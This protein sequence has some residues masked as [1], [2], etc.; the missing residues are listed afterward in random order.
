MVSIAIVIGGL[1]VTMLAH[2][3]M[4]GIILDAVDVAVSRVADSVM[5]KA[6]DANRDILYQAPALDLT[7]DALAFERDVHIPLSLDRHQQITWVASQTGA[8]IL[9]QEQ[10]SEKAYYSPLTSLSNVLK[11][12]PSQVAL[13]SC[14]NGGMLLAL[15][16]E[17]QTFFQW[18]ALAFD[19][20]TQMDAQQKSHVFNIYE[21]FY[22]VLCGSDLT[23][24]N[25]ALFFQS[26]PKSS[27]RFD[28]TLLSY[29]VTLGETVKPSIRGKE[30]L[31]PLGIGA[32][33]GSAIPVLPV[34][35]KQL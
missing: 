20:F 15:N 35:A 5:V 3:S 7:E 26:Y 2:T 4:A 24:E 12:L 16:R 31:L 14:D 8:Y 28:A 22:I 13:L 34:E 10:Y 29:C 25:T 17:G 27:R 30:H 11:K 33:L 6:F 9:L 21:N 19:D 23:Q 32:A 1:E 18:S